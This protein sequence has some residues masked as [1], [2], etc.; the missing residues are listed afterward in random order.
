MAPQADIR[1]NPAFAYIVVAGEFSKRYAKA[2]ASRRWPSNMVVSLRQPLRSAI[3]AY[4]FCR[5]RSP[6]IARGRETGL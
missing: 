3:P 6:S 4:M 2:I 1:G 5:T